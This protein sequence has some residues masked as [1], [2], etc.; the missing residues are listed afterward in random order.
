[1]PKT[2]YERLDGRTGWFQPE[3]CTHNFRGVPHGRHHYSQLFEIVY[4]TREGM[5]INSAWS[6][7]GP[8]MQTGHRFSFWQIT[9]D[10]AAEWFSQNYQQPPD[11]LVEDFESQSNPENPPLHPIRAEPFAN[12]DPPKLQAEVRPR[13][14]CQA[15][16]GPSTRSGTASNRIPSVEELTLISAALRQ[17]LATF[18]KYKLFLDNPSG[19]IDDVIPQY[20][21]LEDLCR[22]EKLLNPRR[23]PYDGAKLPGHL[24]RD[25]PYQIMAAY[26]RLRKHVYNIIERWHV[27][28]ICQDQPLVRGVYGITAG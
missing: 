15:P 20:A 28:E 23:L 10:K 18:A 14:E 24:V 16:S 12:P 2:S 17:L 22:V 25:W 1:M 19:P 13:E 4:R 8:W 21:R 6:H 27:P 11:I 9:R 7:D 26:P 5:W 3:E